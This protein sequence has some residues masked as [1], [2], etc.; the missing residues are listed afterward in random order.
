MGRPW[1]YGPSMRG[2]GL[3]R[4]VAA[5]VLVAGTM[6]GVAPDRPA[7]AADAIARLSI[8]GRAN[9]EPGLAAAGQMVA[10]AWAAGSGAAAD[11]FVA[12]SRD[13]GLTFG[14]PVRANDRPGT[15]RGG[16]EQAPRVALGAPVRAGGEP[17]LVVAWA[18]REPAST[19]RT[20]RSVDGGRT[21]APSRAVEGAG[22]RGN[23]GWVSLALD[24]G[25]A[26]H[27]AWLDH[28]GSAGDATAG[29]HAHAT[30]LPAAKAPHAHGAT[31]AAARTAAAKSA[32][33]AEAAAVEAA[34]ARA[35][36]ASVEKAQ[37]SALYYAVVP[38]AGQGGAPPRSLAAGVC[39]CC[40]TTL[41]A[42][43]VG[44]R[45]LLVAAWRHVY[46]GNLRDMAMTVSGDGGR[47]FTVPARVSEDGW[48]LDGC[49][50]DG[51]SAAIDAA[52]TT[53]LLWPT[54]V[55]A[56]EPY[57]GL[58]YAAGRMAAPGVT[59]SPRLA[60]TPARRGVA[61]PSL[62]VADDGTA[63]AVWDELGQGP[64]AVFMSRKM[65]GDRT[66][67]AP[68]QLSGAVSARYP[69]VAWRALA[70]AAAGSAGGSAVVAWREGDGATSR[71]AVASVAPRD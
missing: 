45:A 51:P 47:T 65:P 21:F 32:A 44:G 30:G 24:A 66:F 19:V 13:G 10:V 31:P 43:T 49:P 26:A 12:V 40:K 2:H 28:R 53:H 22:A 61:H 34:A 36:A 39:Y 35:Q 20:A 52:G 60:V 29:H 55:A 71:I 67:G 16:A 56:P 23:R 63:F 25:G 46:P 1:G 11:L 27:V 48:Q 17:T 68:R 18:G 14:A 8:P 38:A 15:V 57:K 42:R 3:T 5:A 6:S 7:T 4:R 59:L 37:R 50:E 58:F 69:V 33:A 41:A 64:R 62:A 9:Q 54:V 70:G